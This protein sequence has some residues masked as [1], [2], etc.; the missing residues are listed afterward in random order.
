M[1]IL[2]ATNYIPP[3]SDCASD[4]RAKEGSLVAA[5]PEHDGGGQIGTEIGD[6]RNLGPCLTSSQSLLA[7]VSYI[8]PSVARSY[9]KEVIS[10]SPIPPHQYKWPTL[11]F[12]FGDHVETFK[13]DILDLGRM[14]VVLGKNW[15]QVHNPNLKASN[16]FYPVFT[17]KACEDHR[18]DNAHTPCSLNE[19]SKRL[20]KW[21]VADRLLFMSLMISRSITD[22]HDMYFATYIYP[23]STVFANVQKQEE[24]V[25]H[26]R[27]VE[28][29]PEYADLAAAFSDRNEEL[30]EHGPFDMEINLVLSQ[31]PNLLVVHPYYAKKKDGTLWLCVN[32]QRDVTV[33]S[34][35]PLPLIDK[36]RY[37][38]FEYLVMPFGLSNCPGNF[39]VNKPSC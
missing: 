37:G 22:E 38:L 29:P 28:I 18:V 35:Y 8:S 7:N 19:S 23:A 15:L 11:C 16:N 20:K 24:T 32:Y 9:A 25:V 13:F 14:H 3:G 5:A 34:T 6:S 10:S 1:G 39:Q 17:K 26:E 36:T 2:I 21:F 33:K 30:P 4:S 12:R 27:K 31:S